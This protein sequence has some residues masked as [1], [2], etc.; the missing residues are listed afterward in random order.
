[1]IGKKHGWNIASTRIE[2]KNKAKENGEK[3]PLVILTGSAKGKDPHCETTRGS[4]LTGGNFPF[5]GRP[6]L[7][8]L[9]S[10]H[11]DYIGE[12]QKCDLPALQQKSAEV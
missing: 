9:L 10:Y 11:L 6:Q 7:S 12:Y 5:G 2:W 4:H 1:M 3:L 8:S